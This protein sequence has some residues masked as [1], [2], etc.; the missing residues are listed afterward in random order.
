MFTDF[1]IIFSGCTQT[2][3]RSFLLCCLCSYQ[4]YVTKLCIFTFRENWSWCQKCQMFAYA[5]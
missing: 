3:P 2:S 5:L 1:E 4:S